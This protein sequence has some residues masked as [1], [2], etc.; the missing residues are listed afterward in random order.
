LI[1]CW[2]SIRRPAIRRRQIRNELEPIPVGQQHQ[3]LRQG[4]E[5]NLAIQQA[6]DD[7][8]LGVIRDGRVDEHLA[9][10]G[11]LLKEIRKAG[12]VRV[13]LL[14]AALPWRPRRNNALRN[15]RQTR[16]CSSL[17]C[18]A[19]RGERAADTTAGAAHTASVRGTIRGIVSL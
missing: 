7:P 19:C 6:L 9:E 8:P 16:G 14:E 12:Q 4:S 13:D 2:C 17:T 5:G 18:Q 11:V 15:G 10:L 1:T 3:Q